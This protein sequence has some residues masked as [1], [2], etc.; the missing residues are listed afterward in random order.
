[1]G[2]TW[3][4]LA[5]YSADSNGSTGRLFSDGTDLYLA[6]LHNEDG[7]A[8]NKRIGVKRYDPDTGTWS[9]VGYAGLS[10]IGGYA[11]GG[12]GSFDLFVEAGRP[13]VVYTKAAGPDGD[14]TTDAFVVQ[15]YAGGTWSAVGPPVPEWGYNAHVAVSDR[16]VYVTQRAGALWRYAAGAWTALSGVVAGEEAPMVVVDGT[17][18]V[19][20]SGFILYQNLADDF[21]LPVATMPNADLGAQVALTTDGTHFYAAYG[22]WSNSGPGLPLQL[23][24]V[25]P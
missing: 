19:V 16:V 3:T 17:L 9:P 21:W 12:Y 20:G 24:K 25:T 15:S 11:Y 5:P 4:T 14:Q 8:Y 10:G 18:Y 2:G 6:Y 13:Y 7:Y 1:V 22:R 23:F